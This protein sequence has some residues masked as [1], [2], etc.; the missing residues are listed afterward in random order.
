LRTLTE[1]LGGLEFFFAH[2]YVLPKGVWT[3]RLATKTIKSDGF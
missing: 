3:P 2:S 1:I